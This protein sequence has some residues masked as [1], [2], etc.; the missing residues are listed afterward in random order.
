[1]LSKKTTLVIDE[2][3]KISHNKNMIKELQDIELLPLSTRLMMVE[4]IWDSIARSQEDIPVYDWQ[5]KEL[6]LRKTKFKEHPE[7]AMSW[8]NVQASIVSAHA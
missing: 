8:K 5:K 4:D 1:V 6:A 7:Q 2:S 3:L